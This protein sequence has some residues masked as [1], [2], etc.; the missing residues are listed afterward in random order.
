MSN[1]ALSVVP[2]QESQA[3]TPPSH[4]MPVLSINQAIARFQA[5]VDFTR[6]IMR[7]GVD[8]GA[9]PGT[10]KKTLLK[11]GA[12][13][14]TTFFGLTKRFL[15][16]E[17]IEDWTGAEHNGEP[18]FYYL[19]RCQ[20]F[21]GDQLIAESDGSANSFESK[22]RW[23]WVGEDGVPPHFNKA[24]LLSKRTSATE[25]EF[26]IRKAETGGKYGKPAS[27][28]Q[29]W[30]Q[31]IEN[32]EAQKI[33]KTSNSGKELAAWT[34]EATSYRI[35]NEDVPSQVNTL[36]KMAQKRA[37]VAATLLAVNASEFF[38]QDL[39]DFTDAE[40]VHPPPPAQ[41]ASQ[42][43]TA[44]KEILRLADKLGYD[45][46]ALLLWLKRRFK[47]SEKLSAVDA[48]L[49]KLNDAELSQVIDDFTAQQEAAM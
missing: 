6:Q 7:D 18:F 32:G 37:L 38:T 23:R 20:L 39:E 13:K 44:S 4:L 24:N 11:A 41:T 42:D 34:V 49:E 22:Y 40:L 5:V 27:Y 10:E 36:Q 28:W 31:A 46:A 21:H 2:R 43:I 8:F 16:V 12:E 29:R 17:K 15:I 19:Y 1:A 47:L 45:E 35:P 14:L 33:T 25:F 30:Q 3:L 9:V 26:A 48:A